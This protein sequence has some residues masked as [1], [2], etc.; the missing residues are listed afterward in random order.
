MLGS[1]L[2]GCWLVGIPFRRFASFSAP[3]RP[4]PG[5]DM[6][7]GRA[8]GILFAAREAAP[9]PVTPGTT[10]PARSSPSAVRFSP[11]LP[12]LPKTLSGVKGARLDYSSGSLPCP[13][14][15]LLISTSSS[16]GLPRGRGSRR[17]HPSPSCALPAA[18]QGRH[19]LALRALPQRH[20]GEDPRG[21]SAPSERDAHRGGIGD[22]PEWR[23]DRAQP[24]APAGAAC[25]AVRASCA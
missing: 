22:R 21:L 24:R 16:R 6:L 25:V 11:R 14:N 3:C 5:G 4:A 9:S 12:Q 15:G 2:A 20:A 8:P 18:L 1:V 19:H 7:G 23:R 17:T 13:G 10:A